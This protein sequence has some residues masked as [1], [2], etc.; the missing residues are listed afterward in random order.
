VRIKRVEERAAEEEQHLRHQP[1]RETPPVLG[2]EG[3]EAGDIC[4]YE[5]APKTPKKSLK[6]Q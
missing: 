6:N 4:I 2:G 3:A 5:N 1:D